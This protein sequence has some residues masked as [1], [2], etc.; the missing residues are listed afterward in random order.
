MVF[1]PFS[2]VQ[3][4]IDLTSVTDNILQMG[5]PSQVLVDQSLLDG[6]RLEPQKLVGWLITPLTSCPLP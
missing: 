3:R 1:S 2:E 5:V 4:L 6:I